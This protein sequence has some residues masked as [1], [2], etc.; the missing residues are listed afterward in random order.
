MSPKWALNN[1]LILYKDK[2]F[3]L[4]FYITNFYKQKLINKLYKH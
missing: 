2:I 1:K 4:K 3:N